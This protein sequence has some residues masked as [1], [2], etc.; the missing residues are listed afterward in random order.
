MSEQ[1][2]K[3]VKNKELIKEKII[4]YIKEHGY[5]PTVREIC[6][7]TNLKS[8]SSV[9]SYLCKMFEE[10]ELETDAKIGASRA[11]RVPGYKYVKV[12][13]KMQEDNQ[14]ASKDLQT[15]LTDQRVRLEDVMG[16]IT[17]ELEKL[18]TTQ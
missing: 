3:S 5:A 11:I 13:Q 10:G 1:K 14:E 12:D 8:T 7:M 18:I 4:F 17:T 2:G 6:E 15:D 9:Q 16:V